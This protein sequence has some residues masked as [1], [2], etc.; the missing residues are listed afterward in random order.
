MARILTQTV[1][2]KLSRL[3]KNNEDDA[4]IDVLDSDGLAAIEA[5]IEEL[6]REDNPQVIVEVEHGE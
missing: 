1:L 2:I 4:S 6:I 5:T 3:A